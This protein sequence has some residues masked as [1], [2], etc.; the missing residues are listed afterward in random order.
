MSENKYALAGWL[1]IA[2]AV[3]F[4]LAFIIGIL[5]GVIGMAAFHRPVPI[6]GPSEMLFI[7][8]TAI[9]VYA[10]VMLRTL[11]NERYD[12]H[13]IDAL[14]TA[15]ICWNILFQVGSM[16]LRHLFIPILWGRGEIIIILLQLSF[17]VVSMVAI[18]IIDVMVAI[19]LLKIKDRLNE[20]LVALVY[21][22]LVSG[23]LELSIVLSPL[24]LFLVPVNFAVLGMIFL[25]EKE[26]LEFV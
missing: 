8:V 12:Y 24:S 7:L 15:A 5:Q 19:R 10:L 1:A 18:G 17:M 4:P 14:I 9:G 3:L 2:G 23:A 21:I 25:K 16:V 22:T 13:N 11:L 20:L 26:E 6:L